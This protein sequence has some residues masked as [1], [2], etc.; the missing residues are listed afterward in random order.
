MHYE[1]IQLEYLN[2]LSVSQES[3][4]K[5]NEQLFAQHLDVR[6]LLRKDGDNISISIFRAEFE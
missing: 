5:I 4:K 6:V 2:S 1:H 3:R